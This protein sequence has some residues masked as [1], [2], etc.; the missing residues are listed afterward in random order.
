MLAVLFAVLFAV[1]FYGPLAVLFAVMFYVLFSSD[2]SCSGCR[3]AFRW[4]LLVF[5]V[6]FSGGFLWS[7][8]LLFSGVLFV[9]LA[10]YLILVFYV[11]AQVTLSTCDITSRAWRRCELVPP[12]FGILSYKYSISFHHNGALSR[13]P[14]NGCYVV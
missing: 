11:S 8:C 1:I 10:F 5:S 14:P 4:L 6:Y 12:W 7:F 9:L 3:P 2:F 13:C